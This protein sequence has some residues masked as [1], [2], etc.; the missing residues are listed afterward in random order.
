LAEAQPL[1][2]LAFSG[3]VVRRSADVEKIDDEHEGF[4]A[5]DDATGA[6][7]AVTEV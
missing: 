5:L 4:A 7:I 2:A 3:F 1:F 6:T